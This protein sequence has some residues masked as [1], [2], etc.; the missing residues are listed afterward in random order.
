MR[1]HV[2]SFLAFLLALPTTAATVQ[3]L[4]D[5]RE[6][7]RKRAAEIR[8]SGAAKLGGSNPHSFRRDGRGRAL[9]NQGD[10]SRSLSLE[11]Y[12]QRF[13]HAGIWAENAKR[14]GVRPQT[15]HGPE[16]ERPSFPLDSLECHRWK[17]PER[18]R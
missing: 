3:P 6:T 2:S 4:R 14:P 12:S 8:N 9:P 7:C 13:C 16:S 18:G 15:L 11:S 10:R 1:L 17:N 5:G